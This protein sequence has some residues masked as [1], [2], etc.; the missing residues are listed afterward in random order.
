M[1]ARRLLAIVL[2][3]LVAPTARAAALEPTKHTL[4]NGLRVIIKPNPGG[5]IVALDLLLGAGAAAEPKELAGLRQLTQQLLLRGTQLHSGSELAESLESLGAS[6]D[7]S[8]GLDYVEVFALAPASAFAPVCR[9]LAE[10]VTSP[11][12]DAGQVESQRQAA[13][14]FASSLED[15]AFQ[16]AYLLMRQTLYRDHPYG[17]APSGA[18]ESLSRITREQILE[19]Y[20]TYYRPNNC[21]LAV[22]GNVA[23]SPALAVIRE[24]F[25][26]WASG[27]L[28]ATA[29]PP[30]Q[31][32]LMSRLSLRERP[33]RVSYLVLGFLAPDIRDEDYFPLQIADA[34]LSG[35]MSAR[36][37]TELR[38]RRALVYEVS[39]FYPTLAAESHFAA[40]AVCLGRD[41]RE[42]SQALL[43]EFRRL[44]EE[45]V[46]EDELARAKQYLLGSYA[47]SHQ[48]NKQQ[49]YYLAWYELL[50]AGY[51]FDQLYPKGIAAVTAEDVRR[52]ARTYFTRY[53]QALLLPSLSPAPED[54]PPPAAAQP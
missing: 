34:L 17:R 21:V 42:V 33:F 35:G 25:G 16:S 7:I 4:D 51:T 54:E 27:P 32:L 50:G 46:S 44:Q 41:F 8:V 10:I 53:A 9:A 20:Q 3:A 22:S 1:R 47:L 37:F 18:P 31:P 52:A 29:C 40:R 14:Q 13:I 49:A 2:L 30:P 48:R 23:L 24:A 5:D 26:E 45:T 39:S 38:G 36:L 12:F 19:F 6:L 43:A 28:P 15:D 11:L